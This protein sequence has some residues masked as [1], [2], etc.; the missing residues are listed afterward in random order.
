MRVRR[1]GGTV[2]STILGGSNPSSPQTAAAERCEI[3]APSPAWRQAAMSRP[4]QD[5]VAPIIR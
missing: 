1:F 5:G 4:R 3:T 2:T